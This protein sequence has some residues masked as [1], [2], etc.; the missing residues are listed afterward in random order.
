MSKIL[1]KNIRIVFI[2]ASLLMLPILSLSNILLTSKLLI[3]VLLLIT[4]ISLFNFKIGFL[5]MLFLR[6]VLD[7]SVN[8]TLFQIGTL[9]VNMLSLLGFVM[10]ILSG[11]YILVQKPSWHLLS[12]RYLFIAWAIFL[13]LGIITILN[14][15]Y[16]SETVKEI[17]RY[18]SIF[19]TFLIS[20]LLLKEAKDLSLLIK[21]IIWS[22]LAP[23]V[24]GIFQIINK[25]GLPDEQIY[26]AFGSFT[27]PNMFAFFLIL[28][29][30][31]A[32]FLILNIKKNRLEVYIYSLL[33]TFYLIVL[34]FTYTRGAYLA[35]LAI[36]FLIG[37]A[38]FRKFLLLGSIFLIVFYILI[39]PV[40][41]R[42]NSIFQSD[43]YG[44]ISWRFDLWRDSYN[45][46]RERPLKGYGLGN[47]EKIIS[48]KRDFRLGPSEPHN[49]YLQIA[50]DGGYPLLLAYLLLITSLLFAFWQSYLSEIR[51][52]LKNF[53][54]FFAAFCV[55]LFAMSSGDNI[56]N[57]TALQWQLWALAGASLACVSLKNDFEV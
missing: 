52:R 49:D 10:V 41:A 56:L 55:A 4:I 40:Q 44:S 17:F 22:A 50:L 47:S 9:T 24:L 13:F 21:V 48:E 11:L 39:P 19:S 32:I 15:F 35:I 6:P 8:N 38:K 27:H 54:L 16:L 2:A 1:I 31:M 14:T 34:F 33:A 5:L 20:S 46:F 26:R 29:I 25:T 12:R 18:F 42:F 36:L 3:L 51:P 37:M 53:F 57:D 43:P 28:A 23:A 30:I 45:Y 7:L